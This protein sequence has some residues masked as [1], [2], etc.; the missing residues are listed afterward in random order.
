MFTA[1]I[2][3][4][5]KLLSVGCHVIEAG[6]NAGSA[7][8]NLRGK[9]WIRQS[10]VDG[11]KPIVVRFQYLLQRKKPLSIAINKG[12]LLVRRSMPRLTLVFSLGVSF[13]NRYRHSLQLILIGKRLS[14]R[15]TIFFINKS[16]PSPKKS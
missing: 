14:R 16:F 11:I 4:N 1:F 15:A 13:L 8:I 9:Q 3:N 5:A 12:A 2:C 7:D 6:R 10:D